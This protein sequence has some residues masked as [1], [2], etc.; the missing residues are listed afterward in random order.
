MEGHQPQQHRIL[1]TNRDGSLSANPQEFNLTMRVLMDDQEQFPIEHGR[2]KV[3]PEKELACIRRHHDGPEAGHP[4]IARTTEKIRRHFSFP[5]MRTKVAQYIK[6][7]DSCQKNKASRH[8][9]YGNLQFREPPQKPWDEV[10]MDF[11]VKLPKSKDPATGTTYDSILVMVDRL[12]KYSH[13]VPCN[14]TINAEQLG[15]LVLDRLIRYHGVPTTFITDRDKLFTSNYWKN[16]G[17]SNGHQAQPINRLPSTNR[18]TN[19]AIEPIA[20]RI[21]TTLRQL[22]TRQ[23]GT[24]AVNGTDSTQRQSVRNNEAN[25]LHGKLWKESEHVHGRTSRTPSSSSEAR[26]WSVKRIT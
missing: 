6:K 19:R 10:T 23:L 16:T 17:F 11:I 13:F 4:G 26:H 1:K 22:R 15:Y 24:T 20:G 25:A 2:H 14:E 8:A 9:Q 3:P 18:R 12:T 5:G 7:C 21:L